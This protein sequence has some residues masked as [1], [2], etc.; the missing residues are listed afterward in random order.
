MPTIETY[1]ILA[2]SL[3]AHLVKVLA[4][5]FGVDEQTVRAWRHPKESDTH[6]TGTGKRNPLDQAARLIRIVHQY[7]PGGAR[8]AAQ[9]FAELVDEL[10]QRAGLRMQADSEEDLILLH[11]RDEL[12]EAADIPQVLMHENLDEPTL[13]RALKEI[14]ED[15]AAL[16]RLDAVVRARLEKDRKATA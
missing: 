6:P 9:Y 11:L 14:S 10:D 7:N 2:E 5:A 1:E 4:K 13:R 8:Q 3:T 16:N 12:R 15:V